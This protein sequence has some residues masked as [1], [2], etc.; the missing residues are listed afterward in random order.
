M[1][2]WKFAN[3]GKESDARARKHESEG[4]GFE[5]LCK[6]KNFPIDNS[7]KVYLYNHL[8]GEFTHYTHERCIFTTCLMNVCAC[9]CGCVRACVLVSACV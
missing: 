4:H 2:N 3:L 9:V 5:S 6:Q 7:F 8:A 1:I